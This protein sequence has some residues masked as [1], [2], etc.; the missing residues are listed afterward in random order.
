MLDKMRQAKQ[1][2]DMQRKAK[3]MQRELKDTEI[4]AV[5]SDGTVTVV[6][7]GELKL[8][9]L[10]ISDEYFHHHA[11]RDLELVLKTTIGEAMSRAQ[12]VAAEKTRTI[13]KDLN[14]NLPG[15]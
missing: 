8:V 3:A 6:F 10:K 9:E 13:M 12:T 5:S 1:L 14:I 11:V 2:F 15:L 7:N 4:E